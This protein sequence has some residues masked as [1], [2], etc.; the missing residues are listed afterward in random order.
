MEPL[1]KQ[2]LTIKRYPDPVLTQVSQECTEADVSYINHLVPEMTTIMNNLKGVGL[3]AVQVGILMRFCI[4]K[5]THGKVH[6]LINPALASGEN[7]TPKQEGCLSLPFFYEKVERFE[8]VTINFRD[9]TW[10]ERTAVFNGI[11]AQCI[12][13]EINHMNGLLIFNTVS[14]M[15]QEMWLKK[16]R[17][18][19]V[20]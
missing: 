18:K 20:L 6:T 19:G 12:Q 9:E 5:D 3:A 16:A 10:T 11:E 17:K 2:P 4:L 7:L 15:K 14:R 13:H 1:T 8:E